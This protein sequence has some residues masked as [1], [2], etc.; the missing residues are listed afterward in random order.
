MSNHL[1]AH[2]TR[3]LA[4]WQRSGTGGDYIAWLADQ[5]AAYDAAHGITANDRAFSLVTYAQHQE[6]FTAWLERQE[7]AGAAP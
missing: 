4:A 6:A 1:Q 2:S 5:W 7:A 3:R